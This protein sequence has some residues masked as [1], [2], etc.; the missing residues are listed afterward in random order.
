M[1]RLPIKTRTLKQ[2]FAFSGNE[3]AFPNC[4][5][6]LFE[7]DIFVAQVC[8][9]F[10]VN[11][12]WPRFDRERTDE[13]N[14]EFSNLLVLCY[15]HHRI[16]DN[17]DDPY[18]VEALVEI[19]R[20]HELKY[21][22]SPVELNVKKIDNI[23]RQVELF[24]Y[25]MSDLVDQE[26]AMNDMARD[27]R[28]EASVLEFLDTIEKN[29]EKLYSITTDDDELLH[30]LDETVLQFLQKSGFRPPAECPIVMF[31]LGYSFSRINW[32]MRV[33]GGGNFRGEAIYNL[34]QLKVRLIETMVKAAPDDK[35]IYELLLSA[36][37]ELADS[38]SS[39]VYYD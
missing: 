9:I 13:Q 25:E 4:H 20:S 32:D 2:L 1:A 31:D 37:M 8:H 36:R 16:V 22:S 34:R 30:Q 28:P 38:I 24:W 26:N 39:E 14:R 35:E 17:P 19:K 10:A 23:Q 12:K 11:G 29:I 21:Q 5:H 6:P 3:C 18:S 7:G 15:K 27:L 33:I